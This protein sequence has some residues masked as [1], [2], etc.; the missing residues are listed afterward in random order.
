MLTARILMVRQPLLQNVNNRN[1]FMKIGS[2]GFTL[3]ELLISML[4]VAIAMLGFAA[5]QAYSS[6]SLNSTYSKQA[7]SDALNSYVRF[8]E[9][10]HGTLSKFNWGT[11]TTVTATFTCGSSGAV[12]SP[13]S[14]GDVSSTTPTEV[15]NTITA[16][17]GTFGTL[18]KQYINDRSD[19]EAQDFGVQITRNTGVSGID[20]LTT[21]NAIVV[22]AYKPVSQGKFRDASRSEDVKLAT[23]CPYEFTEGQNPAD[24]QKKRVAHN[25]VCNRVEVGL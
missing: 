13:A 14:I 10:S 1:G 25:V 9:S 12:V 11:N 19:I 18:C 2:K 6:R 3:I 7:S 21:F 24:F 4:V 20:G 17:I 15:K 23:F 8:I 16:F 5:L 22:F